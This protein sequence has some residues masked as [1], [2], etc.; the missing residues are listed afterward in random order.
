MKKLLLISLTVI[1]FTLTL[2]YGNSVYKSFIPPFSENSCIEF[3][4]RYLDGS[5][6]EKDS[7]PYIIFAVVSKNDIPSGTSL[8]VMVYE[9]VP[10]AYMSSIEPV[11]FSDIRRSNAVG[12]A[13]D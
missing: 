9:V 1:A 12:V 2:V 6:P 11:L 8:L 13:C 7:Q 5:Q 3:D 4:A 10:G